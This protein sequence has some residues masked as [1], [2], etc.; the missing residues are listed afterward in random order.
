[1]KGLHLSKL[2]PEDKQLRLGAEQEGSEAHVASIR[3][4]GLLAGAFVLYWLAG[5]AC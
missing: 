2:Y 4:Q 1:M 5:F 3:L